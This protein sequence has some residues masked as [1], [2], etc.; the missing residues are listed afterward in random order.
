MTEHV[1]EVSSTLDDKI[2]DRRLPVWLRG[3]FVLVGVLSLLSGLLTTP[4][5]AAEKAGIV[6]S[7]ELIRFYEELKVAPALDPTT[8]LGP[9][10]EEQRRAEAALDGAKRAYANA[11]ANGSQEE[12][13][14]AQRTLQEKAAALQTLYGKTAE[15]LRDIVK[16]RSSEILFAALRDRIQ[17]FG[18]EQEYDIIINQQTGKPMFRREGFSGAPEKPVDIT[19]ELIEWIRQREAAARPGQVTRP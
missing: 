3:R 6:D 14:A 16:Y 2:R 7:G 10:M 9:E 5:L 18:L 13:A 15:D 4:A 1:E 8:Q 12:K 11:R 19:Q 17:A